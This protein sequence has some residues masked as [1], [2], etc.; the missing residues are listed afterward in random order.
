MFDNKISLPKD[1]KIL[2]LIY[3]NLNKLARYKENQIAKFSEFKNKSRKIQQPKKI[4]NSVKLPV[5][6]PNNKKL[7]NITKFKPSD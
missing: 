3:S 2:L 5:T 7:S 1:K 6:N 4:V